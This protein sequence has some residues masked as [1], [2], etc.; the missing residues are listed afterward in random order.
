MPMIICI[1]CGKQ[2]NVR[3]YRT[4]T[5]KYCSRSCTNI[6]TRSLREGARLKAI[7]GRHAHNYVDLQIA[8]AYCGKIFHCPPSRLLSKS[9]CSME[10]YSKA[11]RNIHNEG[12]IRITENGR[13]VLEHRLIMESA[14]GRL[15]YQ[16][17]H[18]HHING[19]KSDNRL[20]NLQVLDIHEHGAVSSRMRGHYAAGKRC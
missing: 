9:H 11:Q 7:R 18:V 14:L 6:G 13:R 1:I 4:T 12:Y 20:E 19:I 8:C 15:L 16:N 10:C 2:F 17:E 3:P 5:A